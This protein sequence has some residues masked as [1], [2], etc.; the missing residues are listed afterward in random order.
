MKGLIR[1]YLV[2]LI[3]LYLSTLIVKGFTYVGGYPTLF[4]GAAAFTVINWLVKPIVKILTLPLSLIT[5]GVFSWLINV[6]MLYLLTQIV[7]QIQVK[8]WYFPGFSY[9]GFIIPPLNFSQVM[10]FV[11]ASFVIALISN[12]LNWISH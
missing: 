1:T 3:A 10:T 11:A 7:P 9:Q 5:L 12:L 8:S 2:T 4:T 6:L